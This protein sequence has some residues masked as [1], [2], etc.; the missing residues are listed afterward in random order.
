MHKFSFESTFTLFADAI[1]CALASLLAILLTRV[2]GAEVLGYVRMA[3]IYVAVS[4][5]FSVIAVLLSKT[6][7]IVFAYASYSS[8]GNLINCTIFKLALLSA[9]LFLTDFFALN[10]AL[11]ILLDFSFTLLFLLSVKLLE[12]VSIDR[13]SAINEEERSINCLNVYV[14]GTSSKSIAA[15]ARYVDSRNY[16]I[17]GFLTRQPSMAGKILSN[18]QVTLLPKDLSKLQLYETEAVLFSSVEDSTKESDGLIKYC[19]SRGICVLSV[20]NLKRSNYTGLGIAEI[21]HS[22]E[23]EFL[24]DRMSGFERS[25]KRLTDLFLS[26]VVTVLFSPL[27]LVIA[28]AIKLNDG[29]P[30]IYRQVRIGRFGRPFYILKF[31][32]MVVDAEA[33]GPALCQGNEDPRLTKL[34]SFLKRHHLDELPQ[35]FNVIK[36]E[37]SFVGYRPERKVFI[38]KIIE[39]DPRYAYLYQIRPGVTSYA[40]LKNGY[41]DTLDKMILRLKYDLYYLNHRSFF[42]DMKI[43]F[44]TFCNIVFGKTF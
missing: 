15:A 9:L 44:D 29:S 16:N 12:R 3:L 8:V 20:P 23:N 6:H 35:L 36:G 5:L 17:K 27:M 37:M 26:L 19:L 13:K 24:P 25:F 1:V 30:V 43:L 33:G 39:V 11:L 38:D 21:K 40:T 34:G 41:T 2:M 14:Y 28:I 7:K 32:T 18:Y 22:L 10:K 4:L 42:F 31:R